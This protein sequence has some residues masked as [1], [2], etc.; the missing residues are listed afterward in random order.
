MAVKIGEEVY[1]ED[2]NELGTVRGIDSDGF[3]VATRDGIESLS[4]EHEKAGKTFGEAELLWRCSQCGELGDID[5]IPESCPSCSAPK[6]D[7]YYWTED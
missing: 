6:T 1:D 5:E 7:I 3:F 2:G 4:V